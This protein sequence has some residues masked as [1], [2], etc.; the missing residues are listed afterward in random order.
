MSSGFGSGS[1]FKEPITPEEADT[2]LFRIILNLEK[3]YPALDQINEWIYQ[4]SHYNGGGIERLPPENKQELEA[5]KKQLEDNKGALSFYASDS[6][7]V[8]A[9]LDRV[10]KHETANEIA[11]T[12]LV[13]IM[14]V[15]KWSM[16]L[17]DLDVTENII[18]TIPIT[19]LNNILADAAK[20]NRTRIISILLDRGVDPNY[21]RRSAINGSLEYTAFEIAL[22]RGNIEA[23]TLLLSKDVRIPPS[24]LQ[25]AL[26]NHLPPERR[27]QLVKL[28]LDKGAT[29]DPS[30]N[31]FRYVGCSPP[32]NFGGGGGGRWM[33]GG[34]ETDMGRQYSDSSKEI[35]KLL[36]AHGVEGA[37]PEQ[38]A[39]VRSLELSGRNANHAR[40]L[41]NSGMSPQ[42][43]RAM[44]PYST[45]AGAAGSARR[46]GLMA[47]RMRANAS[48]KAASRNAAA[49]DATVARNRNI[50]SRTGISS[51]SG[52]E[53]ARALSLTQKNA[54]NRA[55]AK[56]KLPEAPKGG[57]RKRRATQKKRR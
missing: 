44:A 21:Q 4:D 31:I 47:M 54:A 26:Y 5:L 33:N 32:F 41:V 34:C 37:T 43:A 18:K 45:T 42:V 20:H 48:R 38:I 50:E 56:F 12:P 15:C 17:N 13:T 55:K 53:A 23:V 8:R 19:Y 51:F 1:G 52:L 2:A 49:R 7:S 35:I 9:N 30:S 3:I 28:L 16:K 14:T 29:P 6:R 27:L 39:A 46:S 25:N 10:I 11:D 22:E 36:I 24:A 40:Q 57:R